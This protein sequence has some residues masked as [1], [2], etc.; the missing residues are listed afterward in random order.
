MNATLRRQ[1]P[2]RA[3]GLWLLGSAVI[4]LA[5]F[6]LGAWFPAE[7][8]GGGVCISRRFFHLPCPGCGMTRAIAAIARGDWRAALALQPL[9]P[10]L[11]AQ[12]A[13]FWLAVL[14]RCLRGAPSAW[15]EIP[16][17]LLVANLAALLLLWVARLATGTLPS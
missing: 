16:R 7:G 10:L 8:A 9:A 2:T 15:P 5:F 3:L 13:A 14:R 17:A 11:L 6:G 12:G 4:V 1:L